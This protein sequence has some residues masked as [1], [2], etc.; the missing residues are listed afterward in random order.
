MGSRGSRDDQGS[1]RKEQQSV[2]D[3]CDVADDGGAPAP[4]RLMASLQELGLTPRSKA[5]SSQKALIQK[6]RL[7]SMSKSN[8]NIKA[9][10]RFPY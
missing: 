1:G 3:S 8:L 7:R 9:K 6:Q 2:D 10:S 5:T 4:R